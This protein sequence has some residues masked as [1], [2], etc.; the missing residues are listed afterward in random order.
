MIQSFVAGTNADL[1][2][3]VA[4]LY[5]EPHDVIVDATYGRGM[6]WRRLLE[7]DVVKHDIALDGV[8][9]RA[10]PEAD[11]TVDVLVLDPPYRLT[12]STPNAGYR[13]ADFEDRY[14]LRN[15]ELTNTAGGLNALLELYRAGITEAARVLSRR[16]RVFIKCQDMIDSRRI[17]PMGARIVELVEAAELPLIDLFVL[18]YRPGPAGGW[19]TQLR[20]RR[21]HSYLIVA[22]RSRYWRPTEPRRI[23]RVH[24]GAL[25]FDAPP[26]S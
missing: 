24:A 1:M 19:E 6:F 8:D 20:A 23:E 3:S 2:R 25:P 4:D 12:E 10:L 9:L 5:I 16:G 18:A 11:R 14:G 26:E 7:L 17:V 15:D 22:G 21:A 13:G